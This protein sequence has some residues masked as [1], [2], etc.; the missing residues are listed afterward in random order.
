MEENE[1]IVE[2][3]GEIEDCKEEINNLNDRIEQLTEELKQ[4]CERTGFDFNKISYL[5]QEDNN[6]QRRTVRSTSTML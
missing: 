5:I 4:V 3:L 6:D 1:E 2:I